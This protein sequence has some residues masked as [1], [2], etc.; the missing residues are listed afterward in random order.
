M[1]NTKYEVRYSALFK[2]K[3]KRIIKQGK[4]INKLLLV[5]EVLAN[6]GNLGFKYKNHRLKDD[7]YYKNCSEC[8]IEPDWLLVYQYIEDK[9]I[10]VLVSTGSH[11]D[12]FDK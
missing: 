4:D 10:L 5:V 12:L 9:L 6:K 1:N 3:L 8:H 7:K 11:S 2:K